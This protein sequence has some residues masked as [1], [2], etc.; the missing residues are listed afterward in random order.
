MCLRPRSFGNQTVTLTLRPWDLTVVSLARVVS[1]KS[2]VFF[3]CCIQLWGP[4][5]SEEGRD[6]RDCSWEKGQKRQMRLEF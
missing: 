6:K 2:K 4:S 1:L 3:L 5:W